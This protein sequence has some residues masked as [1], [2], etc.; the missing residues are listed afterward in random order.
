[1]GGVVEIVVVVVV[2]LILG[3][4]GGAGVVAA[5]G[6]WSSPATLPD[7]GRNA[8]R[9]LAARQPRTLVELPSSRTMVDAPPI[10]GPLVTESGTTAGTA[11]GQLAVVEATLPPDLARLRDALRDDLTTFG[12]ADLR[13]VLVGQG[14]RL[15]RLEE[16]FAAEADNLAGV[17]AT[18]GEESRALREAHA[19]EREASEARQ[20]AALERL[21][22]GV[23]T[24]LAER[25]REAARAGTI[26]AR[27]WL[28]QRRAEVAAD[29]YA[30]LARLEAAVA[31]VTNPILLPGEPY[32]PPAELLPDALAW[33]NWK[34][35]GERA[36]AF[37]DAYSAQGLFLD[38]DARAQVAAF[39]TTLRGLL[40]Q[41]IYPN[42][43]PDPTPVQTETLR[44]ALVTLAT[45]VPKIRA[46][47]EA[48]CRP[49]PSIGEG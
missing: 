31:A 8:L 20:D 40:T 25:E 49:P 42:L 6:G 24:A 16:R 28:G 21:R 11:N 26:A 18:I 17:M 23:L 34:D 10:N 2:L 13:D 27:E 4:V 7:R 39:V 35:V 32:A 48:A 44:R 30:R 12:Q 1:M 47:F 15:V 43:R 14:E 45:T 9:Q 22:A 41:S 46:L 29:L 38:D 19:L 3:V 37:A 36:F 33:E 5:R